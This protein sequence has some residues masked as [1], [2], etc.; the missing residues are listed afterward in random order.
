M[1]KVGEVKVSYRSDKARRVFGPKA[2]T[3]EE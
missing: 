1:A 3:W 2:C